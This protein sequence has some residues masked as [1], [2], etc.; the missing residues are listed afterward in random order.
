MSM[1]IRAAGMAAVKGSLL[2]ETLPISL[3]IGAVLAAITQT[4]RPPSRPLGRPN[5]EHRA[6]S[7]RREGSLRALAH[8][9][10][11]FSSGRL[12]DIDMRL[13][14]LLSSR[15]ALVE[16]RYKSILVQHDMHKRRQLSRELATDRTGQHNHA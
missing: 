6:S 11:R 13:A 12:C 1:G 14:T 10:F 8:R 16:I 15:S 2:F 4:C 3:S 9:R 5:L 7:L